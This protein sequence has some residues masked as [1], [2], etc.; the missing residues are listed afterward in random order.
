MK[1]EVFVKKISRKNQIIAL[2]KSGLTLQQ[3]SDSHKISINYS[4]MVLK[5]YLGHAVPKS[6]KK[7]VYSMLYADRDRLI[8]LKYSSLR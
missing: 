2:Y 8:T 3:I 7:I 5:E 4:K 1:T 6:E